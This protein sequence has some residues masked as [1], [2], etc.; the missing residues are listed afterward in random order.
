MLTLS[1]EADGGWSELERS[2]NE[3]SANTI[4]YNLINIG[5]YVI[6][7]VCNISALVGGK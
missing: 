5:E 6:V 4:C 7:F 2:A 1:W 3:A